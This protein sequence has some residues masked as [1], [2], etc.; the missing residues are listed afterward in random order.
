[1]NKI[2]C[3]ILFLLLSISVFSKNDDTIKAGKRQFGLMY[4]PEYSFRSLRS[5]SDA[6][7]KTSLE[8]RDKMDIPK[9]GYSAGIN[10]SYQL[11]N[12]YSFEVQALFSDKGE[13]TKKYD[14][15][16]P[17]IIASQ[18]KI[19]YHISFINHYYYLD[20]P[21]KINYYLFVKK[22]KFYVTAGISA[23]VFLF[24]KTTSTVD[25]KDGSSE[26]SSSVSHPN[27]QKINFAVLL[28]LGMNY[29][30]TDKYVLKIEPV[31]KHSVISIVN[32]PIKSYL[33]SIGL[34]VGIARIF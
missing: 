31:Y 7:A 26:I 28:G 20:L 11:S 30:I 15:Q 2:I 8:F 23:N 9:F 32:A 34:N 10:F 16:N 22:V 13:R 33:Y 3:P 1:M 25:N 21:L 6:D 12:K 4:S 19:P 18:D 29:N 27:F 14:L 5:T 17:I 24:Q